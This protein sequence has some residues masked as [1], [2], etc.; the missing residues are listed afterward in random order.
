MEDLNHPTTYSAV[1]SP[2]G[3][4]YVKPLALVSCTP[5]KGFDYCQGYDYSYGN[6][7]AYA[8]IQLSKP[9]KDMDILKWCVNY[10]IKGDRTYV[11]LNVGSWDDSFKTANCGMNGCEGRGLP[12][13]G[14]FCW[15][16][17]CPAFI[18][19]DKDIASNGDWSWVTAAYGW[20]GTGNCFV[21]PVCTPNWQV[22]AWGSCI[23]G[24]QTRTVIDTN[25]CGTLL[26]KPSESQT[27]TIACSPN[28]VCSDWSACT[29]NLQTR[30]CTDS[31]SCG[32]TTGKPLESQSCTP[33]KPDN[34]L[35]YIIL[36]VVGIIMLLSFVWWKYR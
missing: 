18:A 12:N 15:T 22:G 5:D 6:A 36:S 32:V 4:N 16:T 3:K 8:E 31:N 27:C 28:W 2:G 1:G 17:E 9:I 23:N 29:N 34:T 20:T 26:N 14:E 19:F 7:H 13:E 24:L 35:L 33:D 30:V 25:N 21:K 11:Y 10:K